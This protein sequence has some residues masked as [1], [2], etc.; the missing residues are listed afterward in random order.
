MTHAL[1]SAAGRL[2]VLAAIV[3]PMFAKKDGLLGEVT[4]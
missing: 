1:S 2:F 3:L 4:D